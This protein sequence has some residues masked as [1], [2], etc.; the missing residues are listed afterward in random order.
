[1]R[2][3]LVSLACLVFFAGCAPVENMVLYRPAAA[4]DEKE[5]LPPGF[6]DVALTTA[7]GQTIHARWA[8]H[9]EARGA[10]LYCHGNGGNLQNRGAP[11]YDLWRSQKESVLI[12]DYPGYGKSQGTPTEK[13]CYE[14]AEAGY[15]WLTKNKN[16]SAD[17]LILYGESL[18][19]GPAVDL[20]FR[21]PHRA[22]VLVRT[23]TSIPEVAD[24]QMPLFP[25]DLVMTNRFE[26][27][28]KMPRCKQPTFI[29]QADEDSLIPFKHGQRLFNAAGGPKELCV[30]RGR[31]HNDPLPPE[32]YS[33]LHQFLERQG[34]GEGAAAVPKRTGS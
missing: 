14:A 12:F 23:F 34:Q 17:K 11:V 10:I 25:A 26:N 19:G 7:S 4:I 18:G 5:P 29:A 22:L 21:R 15:D 27:L 13:G 30:L 2:R 31:G 1:M 28:T 33:H 9:P 20:A 8:P 16:I 32:F 24:Y 3:T 6:E